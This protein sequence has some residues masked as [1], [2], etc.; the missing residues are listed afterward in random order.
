[1]SRAHGQRDRPPYTER[2]WEEKHRRIP[3]Y[4]LLPS[5]PLGGT[6]EWREGR[7]RREGGAAAR[8]VAGGRG[9]G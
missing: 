5:L 3:T 4:D 2:G 9:G 6:A 1:M 8:E 7:E